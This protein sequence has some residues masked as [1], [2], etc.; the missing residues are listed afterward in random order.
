MPT[1][2]YYCPNCEIT[3]DRRGVRYE[4]R[5]Y[6]QCYE[7]AVTLVK[8][9]AMPFTFIEDVPGSGKVPK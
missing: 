6:Q 5:D 3:E 9:P 8:I 1:Y 7:C 2:C 4:D